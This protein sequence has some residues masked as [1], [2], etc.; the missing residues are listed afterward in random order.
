MQYK[1]VF[2]V[3]PSV[4]IAIFVETTTAVTVQHYQYYLPS[5]I[6]KS[7][8]HSMPKGSLESVLGEGWSSDNEAP[9]GQCLV[10][11]VGHVGTPSGS[12]A[13]DTVYSYN[14]VMDQLNFK[15]DGN[16]SVPGFKLDASA[17]YAYLLK[18]TDYSQTFIYR[19]YINLKNRHF[20]ITTEKSP[21]TWIGQQYANDPV[22]FRAYC[23]DKFISE[24]K[25][26]G[27][28]YVAVKFLFHS[29]QEKSEFNSA[30]K[31]AF[32]SLASLNSSLS[33]AAEIVKFDGDVSVL[34]FQM[35]GDP[36]KLG[37]I[38]GATSGASQAPLLSCELKNLEA[39]KQMINQILIYASQ[40]GAG[41][42]PG[43]FAEDDSQALVGP[44]VIQNIL[45]NYAT[46]VPVK[47]GRSLVTP[48]IIDART[49]LSQAYEQS[50]TK[51]NEIYAMI[52]NNMLLSPDYADKLVL[53]KSN[54][55]HNNKLLSDAGVICYQDDLS[56]CMAT[57]KATQ[58]KLLPVDLTPFKKRIRMIGLSESSLY[59][60]S[61]NQYIYTAGGQFFRDRIFT[62]N[63]LTSDKLIFAL[64]N[65]SITA[66]STNQGTTYQ[67]MYQM[68][69][70][71]EKVTLMPDFNV[72][73]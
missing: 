37:Q 39:C 51:T 61:S 73:Y 16:F 23:G 49:R 4:F 69:S 64:P 29:A 25:I 28:F 13:M 36:A 43:Q 54:V 56:Q 60:Y 30:L 33:K 15:F 22:A 17:N 50:I 34:A 65:I 14:D 68:G 8:T 18:D 12:V 9:V 63:Q 6:S 35:G 59:P 48:E 58:D 72:L 11:T 70:Y 31:V 67:G 66:T 10:G 45:Q 46:V 44:G 2:F 20:D 21:L 62:V 26:G 27:V 52:N 42:F 47:M 57:E 32:A 19:A 1:K 38:L 40:P 5:L 3:F 55:D 71:V 53:L 7:S 41:N 24:Q